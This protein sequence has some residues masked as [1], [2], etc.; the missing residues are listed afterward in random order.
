MQY[1][2]DKYEYATVASMFDKNL[3]TRYLS[4]KYPESGCRPVY[5]KN[6][7]NPYADYLKRAKEYFHKKD[8]VLREIPR[9]KE[10]HGPA[11][12]S[13]FLED[14]PGFRRVDSGGHS[15]CV[16]EL[17]G[18]DEARQNMVYDRESVRAV[19][20]GSP[21]DRRAAPAGKSRIVIIDRNERSMTLTLERCP[22]TQILT[23][24]YNTYQIDR[25]IDAIRTLQFRPAPGHAGL[26]RLIGGS[27]EWPVAR[28]GEVDSWFILKEGRDG[29]EAQK[30][31]IRM[32]LGTPDFA[33]LEG[34]PGSGKTTVLA[35]LVMQLA[36]AGKRVL[37]CSST[38]VAVDNLLE[39]IVL[40]AG[41]MP[42]DLIPLRIGDSG[43]ITSAEVGKYQ[44]D[45]YLAT[46]KKQIKSHLSGQKRKTGSQEA[47]LELLERGDDT[48][49]TIARDCA[50]LVCGTTIGI[51]R[52]PGIR[53]GTDR[54]DYMILDEASKTTFQEFLV[55]A[56]F[57]DRW[58]VAG[59][60]NQ[61]SPYTDDE[62]ISMHVD[63]CMPDGVLKVAC[64]DVFAA[65]KGR[66]AII[67]ETADARVKETYM[68]RC[69][70]LGVEALDADLSYAERAVGR[71]TVMVGSSVSLT[72]LPVPKCTYVIRNVPEPWAAVQ[73]QRSGDGAVGWLG[74]AREPDY[75]WSGE[76]GWRIRTRPSPDGES[77][78]RIAKEIC[79]L[80]P[81]GD[82]DISDRLEEVQ[83]IAL[84]SILDSLREGAALVGGIPAGSL[85]ER[86]GLL[87][88]QFR[89]H[90]DIASFSHRR[91]YG[92]RALKTPDF[93]A[94]ERSWDYGRYGSRLL[95][96]DVRGK[97]TRRGVSFA[98]EKEAELISCELQSFLDFAHVN[99]K[100]DGTGWTVAL[101]S[102]Y[103]GQAAVLKEQVR[104]LGGRGFG[105]EFTIDLDGEPL[106]I[107][108][109]TV[110]RFQGH[111]SDLVFLS[112][113]RNHPTIFLNQI[114]RINV[115]ITRAR[116]QCVIVGD[117]EAMRRGGPPLE[118]LVGDIPIVG[119]SW[120]W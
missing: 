82:A 110:D 99:R 113:A 70:R 50:N 81:D 119:G 72:G 105:S 64:A 108:V 9:S 41:G 10:H 26:L 56:I 37:F 34:P 4:A 45:T 116:Y 86:R 104:R 109:H 14:R 16:V 90:P 95:W 39:R 106:R 47:L 42:V 24:R 62:E 83:R 107:V 7:L 25:Q 51:L 114:N 69:E 11:S 92:G 21:D 102:F 84:P 2:T 40:E 76:V 28:E 68:K 31:F 27:R 74:R 23:I 58:I 117:A 22:D 65:K 71:G 87:E 89:M 19:Y 38:H 30:R 57:A 112:M 63:T 93:V 111:E 32:A 18:L 17:L 52:Y 15:E 46:V 59:D 66:S 48:A 88:W 78:A 100:A 60:A 118:Y 98:N 96:L 29:V 6:S 36:S 103:T 61:L 94:S 67:V 1:S 91:V 54:F 77:K 49:G 97:T 35:E 55:P 3:F 12:G 101:L 53:D 79:D 120:T 73:R 5:V 33:F 85:Q 44:Y 75:S 20:E 13:E 80:L 43:R 115:A 8:F